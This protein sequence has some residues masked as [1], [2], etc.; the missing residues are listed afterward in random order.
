MK[1]FTDGAC[2]GNPGPGGYGLVVMNDEETNIIT[3]EKHQETFTT[4]NIQELKALIHAF[5][6]AFSCPNKHFIIYADSAY[7]I[8]TF[9]QWAK[10]WKENGWIKSDNKEIKNLDLIKKGYEIF[11][12]L[13]NCEIIKVKGHAENI[14][15][16]LADALAA[17][18]MVKFNKYIEKY[19][20]KI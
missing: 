7:A 19:D 11:E 8:N 9:T 2:S 4:N 1:I 16:E 3:Y 18:N 14:G 12:K 5:A 17:D 10:K 20:L 13:S 6:M 15:N